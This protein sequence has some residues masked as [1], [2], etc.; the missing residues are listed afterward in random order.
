MSKQTDKTITLAEALDELSFINDS[1]TVL[2]VA[3]NTDNDIRINSELACNQL[4]AI[5]SILNKTI[6]KLWCRNK[7]ERGTQK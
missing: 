3:I 6:E 1:L 4:T 5:Q 7:M 2:S